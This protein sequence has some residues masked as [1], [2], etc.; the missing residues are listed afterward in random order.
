[1]I[2]GFLRVRQGSQTSVR[3]YFDDEIPE[4]K[5]TGDAAEKLIFELLDSQDI[6]SSVSLLGGNN[7]GYDI[8]YQK[9]G[10]TYF[11]EVKGLKGSWDEVDVL[12]SRAQFE[13]AQI[14][15]ERYTIFIVENIGSEDETRI[16]E[17]INPIEYFTKIQIDVGWRNFSQNDQ[18]LR[19]EPGRFVVINGTKHK[20]KAIDSKDSLLMLVL[21]NGQ[22]KT[23]RPA[24]MQVLEA[25]DGSD[26]L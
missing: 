4:N 15:G 25:E 20:I 21:E 6:T 8:E 19:P 26:G 9:N 11:A 12:L 13:K 23:F 10:S 24:K 18:D 17:L 16:T 1:M 7:K 22:Q 2:S 3:E 14:E 5:L